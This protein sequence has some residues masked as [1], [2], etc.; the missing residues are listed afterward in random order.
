MRLACASA[1]LTMEKSLAAAV[2]GLGEK[3]I[4]P[5]LWN[6]LPMPVVGL[7]ARHWGVLG[8]TL[9]LFLCP[10]GRK[11]GLGLG[12]SSLCLETSPLKETHF[13]RA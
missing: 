7:I 5:G 10:P 11:L 12:S 1:M 4:L 9:P 2:W 8:E 13:H 6:D 3:N